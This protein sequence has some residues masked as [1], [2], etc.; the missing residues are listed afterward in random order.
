VKPRRHEACL[1]CQPRWRFALTFEPARASVINITR[2]SPAAM[3]ASHFGTC[4][5]GRFAPVRYAQT[6]TSHCPRRSAVRAGGADGRSPVPGGE[7]PVKPPQI[8]GSTDRRHF[9]H[10][11]IGLAAGYCRHM[12]ALFSASATDASAPARSMASA[13]VAV[14]VSP[15][16][17]WPDDTSSRVRRL[18]TA[19]V[20]PATNRAC[21]SAGPR[22]IPSWHS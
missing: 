10:D 21:R 9:V 14:R 7:R 13:L 17:K 16:T 20:A 22:S 19:P 6:T 8:V 2:C 18:P 12:A 5:G 11:D 4:L 15:T 1:G 3:R